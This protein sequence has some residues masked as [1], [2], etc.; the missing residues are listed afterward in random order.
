MRNLAFKNAFILT[1]FFA[2]S[3][4]ATVKAPLI[5]GHRGACGYRPEHTLASYKLAIEMGA[6]YIEPDLVMT[7]DKVL[8]A[9][10]EN[11]ISGTTDVATKF[12]D[13]KTTKSVDG[14]SI[15]GWFIEDFSLAEVKTLRAK[16][17]LEFR[18]H[19]FDGQFEI[20]TFSEILVLI[21]NQSKEKK[22]IIGVYPEAKHPTYFTSVGLPLEKAIVDELKKH[23][24]NKKGSAVYIQSFELGALEK[25]KKLTPLPLI[26]L[27]DDPEIVP[28]DF[29]VSGKTTTYKQL[30]EKKQLM[31]ISKI[32][33]GIGPYKRYIIPVNEKGERMPATTLVADAHAVG[34]LVHPYTFRSEDSYL[35]KEYNG[36]P[37]KEYLEFF[38]LGVDGVFSDFADHAV[39]AKQTYMKEIGLDNKTKEKK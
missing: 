19:S 29:K 31:E 1:V 36:D 24:L 9:R 39:K 2:L 38:K 18:D 22:R 37:Q 16:E 17:R 28:F 3:L 33:N 14:K 20:P 11:E 15:T 21:A 27:I 32:A 26:F 6:D 10:H 23:G 34:L 25:F 4:G 30:L 5:L 35:L 12:P 7:K 13:R 8:M